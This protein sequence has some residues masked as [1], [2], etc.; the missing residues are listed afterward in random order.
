MNLNEKQSLNSKLK[1]DVRIFVPQNRHANGSFH[2]VP[3]RSPLLHSSGRII[4][5]FVILLY[6]RVSVVLT[7]SLCRKEREKLD[8]NL[9]SAVCGECHLWKFT[10]IILF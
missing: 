8:I 6:I 1:A 5:T 10:N 7:W 3:P 9:D 4:L 2:A